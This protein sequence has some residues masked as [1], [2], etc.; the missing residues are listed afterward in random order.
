MNGR[1]LRF[2]QSIYYR[3]MCRV[4]VNG[5]I[6]EEFQVH[7]G[8]RQGCVLSPLL[9]SLHINSAVKRLKEEQYGV[10]CGDAIVPGMLFADDICLVASDVSG[11]KSSL[12]VLAKLC[13]V[14]RV[15][16]NVAKS[17][18]M[19]IHKKAEQC[20]VVYEVEGEAI[21]IVLSYECLGCI[22]DEYLKLTEMVGD[23]AESG[24]RAV[25]VC[26]KR[27]RQRLEMYE[28]GFSRN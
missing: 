23:K 21:P 1:F 19:H 26:L 10:Q 24:M 14:W 5:H 8:L 22:V 16:D 3:N 27:Y 11:I 9:F 4:K 28:L 18:I 15:K 2:L 13:E 12:D 20:E 17:G 7:T 25:G 6:S